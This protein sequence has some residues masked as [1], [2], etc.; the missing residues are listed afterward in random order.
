M[1]YPKIRRQV[2][3]GDANTEITK[4]VKSWKRKRVNLSETKCKRNK[5][6]NCGR[7]VVSNEDDVF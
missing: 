2:C 3:T 7:S 5:G 6:R 4:I 1:K